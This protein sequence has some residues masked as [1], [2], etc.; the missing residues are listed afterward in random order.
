MKNERASA[1]SSRSPQR[2]DLVEEEL[3]SHHTERE[4]QGPDAED[5]V[6]LEPDYPRDDREQEPEDDP[7][8]LRRHLICVLVRLIIQEV[9]RTEARNPNS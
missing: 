7:E 4:Q 1:A 2:Y 9:K 3:Q 6:A 5:E 8:S